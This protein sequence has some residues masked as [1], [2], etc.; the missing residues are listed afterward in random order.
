[1]LESQNEGTVYKKNWTD[2]TEKWTNQE[3]HV[4]QQDISSQTSEL[5]I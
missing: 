4:F 1:M 3:Q 2:N 5:R